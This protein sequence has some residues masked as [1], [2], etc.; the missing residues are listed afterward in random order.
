MDLD[1]T[2]KPG[3]IEEGI[4]LACDA[5]AVNEERKSMNLGDK[6]WR[7]DNLYY[8]VTTPTLEEAEAGAKTKK[9]KFRMNMQQEDFFFSVYGDKGGK[10]QV[11]SCLEIILKARQL[12]FTTFA[13]IDALDE[14]L[15]N[16]NFRAGII[17]HNLVDAEDF[18][19]NKVKFAFDNLPQWLQDEKR[20]PSDSAKKLAFSNGSSIRVGTSLRSGTIN[21]LHISEFGKICAKKPEQAREIVTGA[22]NT[23]ALGQ[24]ITVESTA[25]GRT[26]QFHAYC[27]QAIKHE[28]S[29][30]PYGPLDFKLNFYPWW[31]DE[32]YEL[33]DPGGVVISQRLVKYFDELEETIG[34][35]LSF[36]KRYWYMKKEEQQGDDMRREFPSTWEEAFESSIM[37]AYLKAEM[38]QLRLKRRIT[39]VPYN[40]AM[41]VYTGWDLGLNDKT[42]IW[43]MQE[44]GFGFHLID[45]YENSDKL[46]DHYAKVLA[47]KPY[48]YGKHYL[49]HDGNVRSPETGH[50]RKKSYELLGVKPIKLVERPSTKKV[51]VD[52]V[53]RFLPKCFID[54]ENCE[55]GIVCLDG[56]RREWDENLE[57]YKDTPLKNSALHGFDGLQTLALGY[58]PTA[59]RRAGFAKMVKNV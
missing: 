8:I 11:I 42:T 13:C 29:G 40:P 9:I 50:T 18:F 10:W 47:E 22:F 57:E 12:G 58:R 7:M 14:C 39:M 15:F 1:F 55:K 49:P 35:E 45:Y 54:L 21:Y 24:R 25:E 37:G 52:A 26:G 59:P 51:G 38:A 33:P 27:I 16:E 20:G 56:A 34:Q 43:F 41:P 48:T 4:N 53:K 44:S 36:P 6:L 28:R 3:M 19:V 30:A 32:K 23:V 5:L 17:A 2:P 31:E 46:H